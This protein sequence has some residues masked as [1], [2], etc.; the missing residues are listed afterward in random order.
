MENLKIQIAKKL[1]QIEEMIES[2]NHKSEIETQKKQLDDLLEEY[3]KD[4]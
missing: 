2:N 3:L 1:K 4:L